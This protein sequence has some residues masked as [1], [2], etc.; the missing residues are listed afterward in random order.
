MG[1][2]PRRAF[3]KR[4]AVLLASI[5]GIVGATRAGSVTTQAAEAAEEA[6]NKSASS[7]LLMKLYGSNWH[8]VSETR[9]LGELPAPGMRGALRRPEPPPWQ[10][11]GRSRG[12]GRDGDPASAHGET[13][14]AAKQPGQERAD[15]RGLGHGLRRR[16]IGG[17]RVKCPLSSRGHW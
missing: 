2:T 12:P 5:T 11:W 13:V 16:G 7:H 10:Q 1:F 8:F 4:G 15:Q 17:C 3:M 14:Q 6:P 9:S